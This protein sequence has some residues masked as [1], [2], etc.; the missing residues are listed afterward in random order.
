MDTK[1]E[2]TMKAT[3]LALSLVAC[4]QTDTSDGAPPDWSDAHAQQTAMQTAM[5]APDLTTSGLPATGIPRHAQR[6]LEAPELQCAVGS[7]MGDDGPETYRVDIFAEANGR[8]ARV[9]HAMTHD[10]AVIIKE[11]HHPSVE[12]IEEESGLLIEWPGVGIHL[13]QANEGE[14][15]WGGFLYGLEDHTFVGEGPPPPCGGAQITCWEPQAETAFHYDPGYGT[16][17]NAQGEEG[18]ANRDMIFVRETKNG[19][20][21]DL[22]WGSATDTMGA[23]VKLT[24]LNLRGADLSTFFLENAHIVDARLEGTMLADI[25]L[26]NGSISGSIDWMTELPEE[27]CDQDNSEAFCAL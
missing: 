25:V 13:W 18:L 22:R 26:Q 2:V 6:N 9:R 27:D 7:W 10:P 11:G 21:A 17:V 3:L 1:Q 20:C 16:C 24:G 12:V 14:R 15:I 4:G 23:E 19:E 8:R 5:T